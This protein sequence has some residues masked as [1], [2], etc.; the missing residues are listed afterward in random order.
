[1]LRTPVRESLYLC[2]QGGCPM[3][4]RVAIFVDAGYLYAQGAKALTGRPLTRAEVVLDIEAVAGRLL[5]AAAAMTQNAP[6]LRIYW[7]D[8]M[9][10]GRLSAEQE[11]LANRH[12]MKLRLG[13]VNSQGQQKGVDT[14][15]VTDLVEL[16][17]NQAI[18]DAVMLTGDEDLR[19][20]VQI[21][22]SFGVRIHLIG[23]EPSRGSQSVALLQEA[24]TT[25]E[26][27]RDLI[28]TFMAPVPDAG[29]HGE[30]P[31]VPSARHITGGDVS[32]AIEEAAREF[33]AGLSASDVQS[34]AALGQT[35]I[36]PPEFD[37]RLLA[38]CGRR[39]G[40]DLA[41]RDKTHMRHV[42]RQAIRDRLADS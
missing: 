42:F 36:I 24:D 31:A 35:E 23:I 15:M 18:G 14:L 27:R 22:Q 1:M 19:I 10:H 7:Y 2:L 28:A 38:I 11:A 30:V 21:A 4:L 41:P 29:E 8:G 37:R 40:R 33:V 20:A 16:A 12:D 6:L 26:W 5:E 9:L 32:E 3:P 17:R 25:V 13:V 39:A 34:L